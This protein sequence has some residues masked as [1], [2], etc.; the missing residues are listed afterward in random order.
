MSVTIQ[1]SANQCANGCLKSRP[2][3]FGLPIENQLVPMSP[4]KVATTRPELFFGATFKHELVD[5]ITSPEQKMADLNTKPA[6]N[7]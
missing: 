2:K 6:V 7:F 5:A 3:Q 4:W 1:L